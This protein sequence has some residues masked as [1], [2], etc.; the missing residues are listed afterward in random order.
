VSVLSGGPLFQSGMVM[1]NFSGV[2]RDRIHGWSSRNAFRW[3]R[4]ARGL[5][6][7]YPQGSSNEHKHV[8]MVLRGLKPLNID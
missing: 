4:S 8:L 1:K 3:A 7:D 2:T 5:S 6:G